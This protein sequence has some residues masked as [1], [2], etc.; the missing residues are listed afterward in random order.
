LFSLLKGHARTALKANVWVLTMMCSAVKK[1]LYPAITAV[2][3]TAFLILTILKKQIFTGV[4]IVNSLFFTPTSPLK[5]TASAIY[6][7]SE[8]AMGAPG[9]AAPSLSGARNTPHS[10]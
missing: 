10:S 5:L 1:E 3:L 7:R 8:N 2:L 4:P 9:N 6:S